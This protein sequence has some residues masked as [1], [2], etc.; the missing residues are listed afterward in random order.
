MFSSRSAQSI[1]NRESGVNDHHWII[2]A[3]FWGAGVA[4]ICGLVIGARHFN[5]PLL[6]RIDPT[7]TMTM[8]SVFAGALA[9]GLAGFAFSAVTGA[10]LFH[11]LTPVQAVPLLLACSITTQ[12][13]SIARLW[14]VMRWIECLPYL[15]GGVIGIPIGAEILEHLSPQRFATAFGIF[16]V[17]YSGYM[18]LRPEVVMKDRS[19]LVEVLA[20]FAGGVTGGATAFPG[21]IP[22]ILCCIRGV[23][24]NEQRGVVQPFILVMQIATLIYFS[25]FHILAAAPASFYLWCVPAVIAGTWLGLRLFDKI[26][27]V[28]FRRLVLIFL[29]AS[30]AI[31]VV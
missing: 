10:M 21:A 24:K 11:W 29:L 27:D 30:G 2:V 12:M 18:L 4:L 22:T 5:T 20:G 9:A 3:S 28:R 8:A 13:F 14:H 15:A 19:R 23:S 6:T 1:A 7:L 17:G 31:L 25:K 16:L 26:D